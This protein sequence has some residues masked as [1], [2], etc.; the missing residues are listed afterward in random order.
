M[1][2][3]VAVSTLSGVFWGHHSLSYLH[4]KFNFG[5]IRVAHLHLLMHETFFLKKTR[6]HT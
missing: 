4:E 6:K 1:S 3:N 5:L 2:H